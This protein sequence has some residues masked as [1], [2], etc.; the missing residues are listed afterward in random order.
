RCMGLQAVMPGRHTSRRH[1]AHK[2]YP[3]LLRNLEITR[4]NQ[5]WA[6]DITYIPMKKGFMYLTAIIDLYSRYI[7][8]WSISNSMDAAWCKEVLQ[9][10]IS[11]YGCPEI[12]NTDQGSQFTSEVFTQSV[13]SNGIRLSMD[14]KGRAIDNV[15][16]ERFWRTIKYEKIYLNPPQDGLDLYA[17]L[18]EYMDYYNHRRRH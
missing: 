14:G 10:A 2:V 11:Q 3:Y 9:E 7:V 17:Q 18:A 16:I 13:F 12:I 5:V 8:G 4:P 6:I 15:F 1:K